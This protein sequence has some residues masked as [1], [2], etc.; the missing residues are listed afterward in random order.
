MSLALLLYFAID[1]EILRTNKNAIVE[2]A[3]FGFL[4]VAGIWG[5][6]LS[7]ALGGVLGAPRIL[8]AMASDKIVHK[9]FA[10]GVG[11]NNEPRNAL[12]LTGGIA[13]IGIMIGEL[14]QIAEI[15]AMLYMTAYMFINLTC[16]FEQW[17]SPDF[18]PSF[19]IPLVVPSIGVITTVVLM[20]QLNLLAAIGAVIIVVLI[21][22]RL[23]RKQLEVGSGDVWNSVWSSIV[24][25]GLK[26]LQKKSTHKRNWEPNILLFSGNSARRK[27]LI[28]FSKGIAG[29]NGMISNFDLIKNESATVLFPKHQQTKVEID[30][31]DDAIFYRQQECQN[32]YRGIENIANTYGFS[33]I[34]PNT[35]L[36]GWGRNTSEP[37][38]FAKMSDYLNQLDHNLLYLD[39]DEQK[40]FGEKTTLDIWWT[41]L[42]EYCEL[43][44]QLSKL[45]LS[46]EDW[47][48]IKIRVLFNNLDNSTYDYV[49]RIIQ[50]KCENNRIDAE[51]VIVNN[52]IEKRSLYELV[53]K[54]SL[55]TDLIFLELPKIES[56]QEEY[57]VSTTNDLL[58]NIGTT[59]LIR[60]SSHFYEDIN[61]DP[62]LHR[63]YLD[64]K[65]QIELDK[66]AVN[67]I[68][69]PSS[70]TEVNQILES[71]VNRMFDE[72]HEFSKSIYSSFDE[73][74]SAFLSIV[75]DAMTSEECESKLVTIFEDFRTNRLTSVKNILQANLK[76]FLANI[77]TNV[78]M[79]PEQ[80]NVQ[81]NEEL[82]KVS[83]VDSKD[84]IRG[85]QKLI[86]RNGVAPIK[87]KKSL[88]H[89]LEFNYLSSFNKVLNIIGLS[90]FVINDL[91]SSKLTE[92]EL[93]KDQLMNELR[94]RIKKEHQIF[95]K[96]SKGH[97]QKFVQK[98]VDD[99]MNPALDELIQTREE[100]K[101]GANLKKH[102]LVLGKYPSVFLYNQQRLVNQLEAICFLDIVKQVSQRSIDRNKKD[103]FEKLDREGS[104]LV[105]GIQ[106]WLSLD[107]SEFL[108]AS[109]DMP[110]VSCLQ[111]FVN[112]LSLDIT[113][114]VERV[115]DD[116]ELISIKSMNGFE[117][118]QENL[119]VVDLAL[120]RTLKYA[121]DKDLISVVSQRVGEWQYQLN[122][123]VDEIYKGLKL[124]QFQLGSVSSIQDRKEDEEVDFEKKLELL[125]LRIKDLKVTIDKELEVL[126]KKLDNVFTLD[127][128]LNK[129]DYS[130]TLYLKQKA[131]SNG[132]KY[133]KRTQSGLNFIDQKIDDVVIKLR[134]AVNKTN[135]DYRT[136]GLINPQS[137][138]ADF[139][140]EVSLDN[141]IGTEIPYF[142]QQL[143]TSRQH[144]PK[145]HLKERKIELLHA[146]SAYERWLG[147]ADGLI[148][149]TGEVQSGKT[150]VK[151]N[152][153]NSIDKKVICI[154]LVQQNLANGLEPIFQKATG[155][156]SDLETIFNEL[157]QGTAVD[158]SDLENFYQLDPSGSSLLEE[159]FGWISRYF[160]K[161]LFVVDC[162]VH[163]YNFTKKIFNIDDYILSSVLVRPLSTKAIKDVLLSRHYAGGVKFFW[164]DKHED[165][166]R[167]RQLNRLI[168]KISNNVEGNVGSAL[169]AWLGGVMSF[170][171][172]T[173]IMGDFEDDE[174]QFKMKSEWE[175]I[176]YQILLKKTVNEGELIQIFGS[177]PVNI[178]LEIQNLLR[179]KVVIKDVMGGIS[180]N[181]FVSFYVVKYLRKQQVIL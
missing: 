180:L 45:M 46:S 123:V 66:E 79:V 1:H 35:V 3:A 49:E 147:G 156:Y 139:V 9:V 53:L 151:Q 149:F 51:I 109:L 5:A 14:N 87:L 121:V 120:R 88:V 100:E 17:A 8:Q 158:I 167:P 67:F 136:R 84:V 52:E 18:R 81:W 130:Q 172:N 155:N 92:G 179:S 138:L 142:Y 59:L 28:Q 64:I 80:V 141:K 23:A 95:L 165:D 48:G 10:E 38:E 113:E 148:L 150:F 13:L 159:L 162:N 119:A 132:S 22:F 105:T 29:Q 68:A 4:V 78:S 56:G 173:L 72:H 25:I 127:T 161:L 2:Y 54:Y 175:L 178:K 181:P 134:D 93:D 65:S 152:F 153:I 11:E 73:N 106:G 40:G 110:K 61:L 164:N 82:L 20:I 131:L 140:G 111:G 37:I 26:N 97:L 99:V 62:A 144:A 15:V 107:K 166:L 83:N 108:N 143:F 75:R 163:F 101:D 126:L 114:E 27:E 116:F 16:L 50:S 104:S 57:F 118:N 32:I 39:F 112:G 24:K 169:F 74:Y 146:S 86:K 34:D 137:R 31:Q 43:T 157:E 168:T 60:A 33:G 58:N 7:S 176:L 91:I 115:K 30:E 128:L 98:V 94:D 19:K 124:K 36:M 70:F 102:L 44:L 154:D 69:K 63:E 160:G 96:Y 177:G 122:S 133:L 6:T 76:E 117:K 171:K 77:Q 12:L 21:F 47:S 42:E 170:E 125:K 129:S 135:Y 55:E 85:K 103:L 71:F 145:K 89:Q 90:G 41:N 174:I